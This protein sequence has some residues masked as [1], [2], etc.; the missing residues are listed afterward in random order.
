MARL[1]FE[2]DDS[3]SVLFSSNPIRLA[4]TLRNIFR[5]DLGI[6]SVGL[7]LALNAVAVALGC[8]HQHEMTN[9][10]FPRA[11]DDDRAID[12]LHQQYLVDENSAIEAIDLLEERCCYSG[13]SKVPEH[14]ES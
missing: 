2:E 13:N 10:E 11:W 3:L 8:A 12:H 4:K 5:D 6:D 1:I 7:Q 9:A 14:E